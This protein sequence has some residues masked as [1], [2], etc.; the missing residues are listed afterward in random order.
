MEI[1]GKVTLPEPIAAGTR[2][3]TE[4]PISTSLIAILIAPAGRV[5]VHGPTVAEVNE[6]IGARTITWFAFRHPFVAQVASYISS[7]SKVTAADPVQ[8]PALQVRLAVEDANVTAHP[9][10]VAPP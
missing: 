2:F 4:F 3:A 5:T 1:G 10:N 6:A 7:A 9:D 8:L